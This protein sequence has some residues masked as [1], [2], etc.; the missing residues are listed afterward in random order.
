MKKRNAF[1]LIE[2]LVVIAII[3]ILASMLLP[4]LSKAKE[5]TQRTACMSDLKQVGLGVSMFAGDNQGYLDGNDDGYVGN[6][7]NFLTPYVPNL[8]A[9]RCPS[10]FGSFGTAPEYGIRSTVF[11]SGVTTYTTATNAYTGRQ[12]LTDLIIARSGALASFA[13]TPDFSKK[14]L[15]MSYEEYGW[16]KNG[17]P[18]ARGERKTENN[19]LNHR[20][21]R[22]TTT[23]ENLA[24]LIPG[25]AGIILWREGDDQIA[26]NPASINDYPDKLDNHGDEGQNFLM[27]DAHVVWAKRKSSDRMKRARYIFCIGVDEEPLSTWPSETTEN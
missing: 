19:V 12:D 21:T 23:A 26:G 18:D 1:T 20:N 24:N 7:M 14:Q 9:F 25:A 22:P 10:T 27:A 11:R 5:R 3:A 13:T 17:G 16:W 4:A 2:L 15:G 6:N 8:K